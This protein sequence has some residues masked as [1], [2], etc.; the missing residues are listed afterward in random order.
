MLGEF[1]SPPSPPSLQRANLT[2]C[3]VNVYGCMKQLML[4]KKCNRHMKTLLSIGGWTY[5]RNFVNP[6]STP[7]GRCTF[8][9]TAV[10]LMK[11]LGFGMFHTSLRTGDM[12]S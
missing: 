1:I 3:S 10:T 5:S 12:V 11:D 8:A 4:L 7:Q 9:S 6:A 2:T